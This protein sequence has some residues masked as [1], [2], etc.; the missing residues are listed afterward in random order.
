MGKTMVAMFSALSHLNPSFNLFQNK[1][2][3]YLSAVQ[4]YE[5]TV[6]KGVTTHNQQFPIFRQCN[7]FWRIFIRFNISV[8]KVF[9]FGRVYI[10][11]FGK[12]LNRKSLCCLQ[13]FLIPKS[14]N[15]DCLVKSCI[16]FHTD[17]VIHLPL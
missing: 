3:F 16:M 5:N 4:S 17:Y 8:C 9:G 10:L 6:E 14:L 2:L 7:N 15:V 12:G 13:M 1:P 11:S